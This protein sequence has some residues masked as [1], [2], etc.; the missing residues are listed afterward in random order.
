MSPK[1]NERRCTTRTQH[2]DTVADAR[3]S[4]CRRMIIPHIAAFYTAVPGLQKVCSLLMGSWIVGWVFRWLVG[5]V[6]RL[7]VGWLAERLLALK[8]VGWFGWLKWMI[9]S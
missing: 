9:G 4:Y 5:F 7:V 1:Y 6:E 3:S 2:H 8:L